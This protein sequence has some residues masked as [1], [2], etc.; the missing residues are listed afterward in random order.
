MVGTFGNDAIRFGVATP[1]SRSLPASTSGSDTPR[2][3]HMK[4]MLPDEQILQSRR[5]AAIGHVLDLHLRHQLQH[6]GGE[7]RGGAVTLGRGGDLARIGFQMRDEF[8]HVV[9]LTFAGLT[10]MLFG[11]CAITMIGSNFV[12][13][14]DRFGYRFWLMTSGGGGADSSV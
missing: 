5:G 2:L 13:S 8:R 3:S 6:L 14:N 9:A 1:S 10:M 11:T 12:A 7:M 4:S